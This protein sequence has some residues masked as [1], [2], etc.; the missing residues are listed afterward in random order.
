MTNDLSPFDQVESL[1]QEALKKDDVSIIL[2]QINR[3]LQARELVGKVLAKTLYLFHQNWNSFSASKS[4]EF[5]DVL[6]SINLDPDNVK[7][8]LRVWRFY[9][10][11]P[12]GIQD[13][14]IRDLIPITNAL[15]QGYS[16]SED[17]W[18]KLERASNLSEIQRTVTVD[19]KNKERRKGTLQI[20]LDN[21]TGSYYGWKDGE[22]HDAGFLDVNSTDPVVQEI[23]EKTLR[24]TGARRK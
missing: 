5:D 12:E 10:Q 2:S 7:R 18:E 21:K 19:I 24:S 15:H 23:I 20:N 6:N 3:M 16:I 17:N 1:M 4:D 9:E 22:R 13:R 8:Y 14:P 11:L